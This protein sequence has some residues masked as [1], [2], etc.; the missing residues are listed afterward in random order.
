LLTLLYLSY[1]CQIIFFSPICLQEAALETGQN[2][3][4]KITS[5][6]S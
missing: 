6:S 1:W 2:K 5:V 4:R 3:T